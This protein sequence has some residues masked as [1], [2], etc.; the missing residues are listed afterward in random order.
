[1]RAT[2]IWLA[3]HRPDTYYLRHVRGEVEYLIEASRDVTPEAFAR[4]ETLRRAFVRSVEIVGEATKKIPEEM[5][6]RYPGVEWRGMARMRDRLVHGYF[7]V[8]CELVWDV[9]TRKIPALKE[10]IEQILRAEPRA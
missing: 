6:A 2:K 3:A 4:D 9:V 8:D 5:R 7:G 10:Q 1:M